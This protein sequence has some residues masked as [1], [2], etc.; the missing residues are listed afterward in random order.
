MFVHRRAG[1]SGL[2]TG[3]RGGVSGCGL[4]ECQSELNCNISG[5]HFNKHKNNK[6]IG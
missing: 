2:W 1:K 5:M 6:Q 4:W 3:R